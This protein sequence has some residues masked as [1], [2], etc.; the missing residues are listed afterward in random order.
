ML[1]CTIPPFPLRKVW[2][3]M[4]FSHP[5]W[6]SRR[7]AVYICALKMSQ[8]AWLFNVGKMVPLFNFFRTINVASRSNYEQSICDWASAACLNKIRRKCETATHVTSD[9]SIRHVCFEMP[10]E[11][12]E[13]RLKLFELFQPWNVMPSLLFP[14]DQECCL[15]SMTIMHCV[16]QMGGWLHSTNRWSR[17]VYALC[18]LAQRLE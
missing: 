16:L 18:P 2:M 9:L 12:T 11:K 3:C 1:F 7:R 6:F 14:D 5:P 15:I 4:F 13:H 8:R 17:A 10:M